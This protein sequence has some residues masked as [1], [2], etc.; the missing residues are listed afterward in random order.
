MATPKKKRVLITGAEGQ[1]GTAL[2]EYLADRYDLVCLT[3]SPKDFPSFVAD[4]ADLDSILPAF[5]GVDA[6]AHFAGSASMS[7][8]WEKL[9]PNNIVGTYNVYEAARRTGVGCVIYASSNHAV[10]MYE[11]DGSPEIFELDDPRSIDHTV[12]FRPDTLYGVSKVFG[13]G[14]ARYFLERHGIRSF[15]LRIGATRDDDDPTGP[16]VTAGSPDH[17]N[18]TT[19]EQRL[20]RMRHAWLSRRDCAQLVAR[21]IDADDV[22][23]AVVYGISNNPRQFWDISHARELLGYDP[24]DSAPV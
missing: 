19:V 11:V 6:V 13:E 9:L 22:K 4:V 23:W 18:L 5:E 14:V 7:S 16:R 21:C 15:C 1:I 12:E 20:K 2:R 3:H 8:P 10:G 17:L 24:K